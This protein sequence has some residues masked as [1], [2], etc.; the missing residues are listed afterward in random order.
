ME[1]QMNKKEAA[2]ALLQR[3]WGKTDYSEEA[4]LDLTLA[5]QSVAGAFETDEDKDSLW[6]SFL[7]EKNTSELHQAENLLPVYEALAMHIGEPR[8]KS[9]EVTGRMLEILL[10]Q[11]TWESYPNQKKTLGAVLVERWMEK[12]DALNVLLS[13]WHRE[14]G[15]HPIHHLLKSESWEVA[16]HV[17]KHSG[18]DASKSYEHD[19]VFEPLHVHLEASEK[20]LRCAELLQSVGYVFPEEGESEL[21]LK[22]VRQVLTRGG[23]KDTAKT[24]TTILKTMGRRTFSRDTKAIVSA[25][26]GKPQEGSEEGSFEFENERLK[27][28]LPSPTALWWGVQWRDA[29]GNR[30]PV[31]GAERF[32][33]KGEMREETGEKESMEPAFAKLRKKAKE[34]ISYGKGEV[35]A[36]CVCATF[37]IEKE[38]ADGRVM[39]T[40]AIRQIEKEILSWV[41]EH[42]GLRQLIERMK[43]ETPGSVGVADWL[44]RTD[45]IDI[46]A[47]HHKNEQGE[48]AMDALMSESGSNAPSAK[49]QKLQLMWK[50][51]FNSLG[52]Q[53]MSGALG[54]WYAGES[55]E[56]R[57]VFFERASPE[58]KTEIWRRAMRKED[59]FEHNLK[60]AFR[61]IVMDCMV[62]DL[63]VVW[64]EETKLNMDVV[65]QH[66]G[67]KRWKHTDTNELEVALLKRSVM[68]PK[69][70]QHLSNKKRGA[71]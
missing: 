42:A 2:H 68:N 51:L 20:G 16:K 5:I 9:N 69:E 36:D 33:S 54:E 15:Q 19:G 71:L 60:D 3:L 41:N 59:G 28:E 58:E 65:K 13:S 70:I 6:V 37:S 44:L 67:T 27:R 38:T 21:C 12:S 39:N 10:D 34:L 45:S 31:R 11:K 1:K 18:F 43:R 46:K 35:W 66:I 57:Q 8:E 7:N 50:S 23:G 48:T 55:Q 32:Q 25:W 4:V 64:P 17:M 56:N 26:S 40:T 30:N 62:K 29:T 22:V 47:W 61:A 24:L 14:S 53:E 63:V 52:A 49:T